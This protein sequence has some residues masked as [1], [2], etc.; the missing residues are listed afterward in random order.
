MPWTSSEAR[1][2]LAA[3]KD[4][5][6]YPAFVLLLLYGVRRGEVLGLRWHDVDQAD[7]QA[8]PGLHS[9]I[10]RAVKPAAA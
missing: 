4:D 10:I 2:F 7:G 9:A 1:T 3:A 8:A 6:L 5:P